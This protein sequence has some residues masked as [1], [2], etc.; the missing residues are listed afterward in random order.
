M[1]GVSLVTLTVS[2]VLLLSAEGRAQSDFNE[3]LH[4]GVQAFRE[5]KFDDAVRHFKNATTLQPQH[6]VAHLY[7]A[8]ALAAEYIPGIDD[9]ENVE[10]GKAAIVAYQK[11]LEI[12]PQSASATKGA[13]I[14]HLQMKDLD[15]AK[16]LY[17]KAIDLDASDPE[18]YYSIGVIDWT[19]AY[20]PRM[21][22]REKLALKPEQALP[23][24]F[25]RCWE[26]RDSNLPVIEDGM[27]MLAK[28]IELRP[29]YDDAM[30]YM[31][32]LYRERAEIRCFDAQARSADLKAADHWVDVVMATKKRKAQ[33]TESRTSDSKTQN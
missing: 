31:N 28:A 17:H 2:C 29:D 30:A 23:L 3:E 26:L 10:T 14:V 13:A 19:E 11:V 21:K 33:P 1:Q 12:N 22:M 4:L 20:T 6:E 7:L 9:P 15:D 8:T 5:A 24:D 25:P 32:L 16:A 27:A 18:T